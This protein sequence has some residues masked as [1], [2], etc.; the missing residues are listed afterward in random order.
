M[1]AH[2]PTG[3][4][5]GEA[6]AAYERGRPE[7]PVE[8]IDWLLQDHPRTVV[9]VGAGTGKLTRA[10][11]GRADAVV[12]VEPDPVMRAAL[13]ERLPGTAVLAGTG[14]AL[15]LPDHYADLVVAGQAWH[16]VDPVRGS[17]EVAR[18]LRPGGSLGLVWNDRDEDDPWIARLGAVLREF[19][20]SPDADYQPRVDPPF[21]SFETVEIPWVHHVPVQ[22]VVDMV[23]S[24]S[25]VIAL[26]DDV[27]DSLVAR[28][29]ALADE[30]TD[31]STGLVPV[32]YVTRGYRTAVQSAGSW[33]LAQVNIAR[34]REPLDSAALA[35]F[36][37][38]LDPV[39]AEAESAPGFV[40]RLQAEDGNATSIQAFGWDESGSA[41]VI[42]NLS[43]WT[44]PEA[45]RSYV[46]SGLHREIL[47]RRREWFHHV[48]EATTALW[49][50][51]AGHR[52]TTAEAEDRVRSLRRFG[53]S[54]TVF[55]LDG[56]FPPP[57]R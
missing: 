27:R 49:W 10:F 14:E 11:I 26:A 51:P 12:A 9:D 32:R 8:V 2:D 57:G 34:L 53:P 29:V 45:L 16:W 25:Y 36:M 56:T 19:G 28:V 15:P 38:A 31:E 21:G 20:T 35:D 43:T 3:L 4:R 37:A 44:S 18:V 22:A 13:A 54:A 46:Y 17:A 41:G 48:A 40:W 33:E 24:R 23:T 55:G 1:P 47:K 6:A 5:F 7:Y 30:A 39:N 52:P 50:V 42:V